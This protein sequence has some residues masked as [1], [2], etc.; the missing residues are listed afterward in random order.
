[1]HGFR[2]FDPDVQRRGRDLQPRRL[3]SSRG[4]AARRAGDLGVPVLGALRR[5]ERVATPERHLGLIPAERARGARP[6]GARRARAT[7]SARYV[8]LDEVLR[9]ARSAPARPGVPAGARSPRAGRVRGAR[10]AIAPRARRSRSTTRRTSSCSRPRAPSCSRFDPLSDDA[11]PDGAGALILAG[12]FPEVFGGELAANEAAAQRDR[13]VRALGQARAGR[14]RRP[15][16]PR[17]RARRPGHVRRSPGARDDD[18]PADARLPRG[19]GRERHAVARRRRGGA[20]ARV[21]LLP[22]RAARRRRAGRLDARRARNRAQRG[23]RRRRPSRR[24]S[25]TCTGRPFR[26]SRAALPRLH[27]SWRERSAARRR[28]HR[29]GRLGRARRSG[30]RRGAGRRGDR[31]LA[32]AS[33]RCYPRALP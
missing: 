31:R 23:L 28:R 12:G 21:P 9:L 30:T 27:G 11:L 8:D 19:D 6:R 26:R 24:A 16:L 15:A 18:A 17:R 13:S 29:R 4:A 7:R 20:R 3:G 1:M 32:S 2:T 33:S 25:C 22:G 10:I 5:D 14:V